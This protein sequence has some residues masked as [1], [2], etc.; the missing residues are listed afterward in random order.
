MNRYFTAILLATFALVLGALSLSADA[1]IGAAP[2]D[3]TKKIVFER[4]DKMK[5]H[6]YEASK[7]SGMD[8]GDIV[9]ISS[10]ES[11][12][13]GNVKSK[14]SSASGAL[15]YTNG[16]WKQD[17]ALYH[18]QL[19]LPANASVLNTRANLL[20]GA[21]ALSNL[22]QFLI[23][24][25]HLTEDTV[26]IGDL[27]MS[28][29][30]GQNGALK[31]INSNSNKPVNQIVSVTVGNRSMFVKPNGQVRTAREFRLHMEYLVQ[32]ERSFYTAQVTK[33]Q[34]VKATA[35]VIAEPDPMFDRD[36]NMQVAIN[37]TAKYMG[38]QL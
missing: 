22:K 17:R 21:T 32:R 37:N 8:M 13:R 20:I 23:E 15:Q 1:S 19:G 3:Y 11:T 24:N 6:L 5:S 30:V 9:A 14:Y 34:I 33:Y 31:I 2:N 16:T 12:L 25:S 35:P 18:K 10:I 36:P 4:F 27:Y 29:L 38:Y 28:H 7:V 26:R